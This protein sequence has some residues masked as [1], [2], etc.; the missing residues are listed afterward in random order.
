VTVPD[1]A[2]RD[3]L[4]VGDGASEMTAT[5]IED[6]VGVVGPLE[7]DLHPAYG[8]VQ[9]GDVEGEV[10]MDVMDGG[11]TMAGERQGNPAGGEG[12]GR[13]LGRRLSCNGRRE[14][15]RQQEGCDA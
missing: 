6:S 1:S 11:S 7:A 12:R 2:G 3:L 8:A 9:G 5:E 15:G 14:Q 10:V 13:A 4:T